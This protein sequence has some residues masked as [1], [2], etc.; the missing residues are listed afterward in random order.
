M[1]QITYLIMYCYDL[2]L[3]LVDIITMLE[4]KALDLPSF[5]CLQSLVDDE[6]IYQKLKFESS[7]LPSPSLSLQE[8]SYM[9]MK[10]SKQE[11]SGESDPENYY[12][13]KTMEKPRGS[14]AYSG[15][16]GPDGE[17]IYADADDYISELIYPVFILWNSVVFDKYYMNLFALNPIFVSGLYKTFY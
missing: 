9:T 5:D 6:L 14:K 1:I 8:K 17:P 16:Y 7:P 11:N 12:S 3:V 15:N 13:N 2:E 10:P 4:S